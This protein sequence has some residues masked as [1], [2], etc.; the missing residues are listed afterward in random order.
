MEFIV[1]LSPLRNRNEFVNVFTKF[2]RFR[3]LNVVRHQRGQYCL[4]EENVVNI[5]TLF[6]FIMRSILLLDVFALFFPDF[7]GDEVE[8]E[9]FTILLK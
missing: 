9:D 3:H 2:S 1:I 8:L 7:S 6:G 4:H 5:G